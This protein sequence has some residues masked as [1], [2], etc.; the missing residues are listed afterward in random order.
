MLGHVVS[1]GIAIGRVK[2]IE[3]FKPIGIIK[4]DHVDKEISLLESSHVITGDELSDLI[5]KTRK[6]L[7]DKEAQIFEAHKMIL[8]DPTLMPQ[9]VTEITKEELT[10]AS[11]IEKI[12]SQ[13]EVMFATMDS[14]YMKER[15]LDIVDIK[16]RWI[17]NTLSSKVS[18]ESASEPVILFAEELTPSDTLEMDLDLVVGLIMEKGGVASH[19]AILAQSM[20]IPAV[21]GCGP[22]TLVHNELIVLDADTPEIHNDLTDAMIKEFSEKIEEQKALKEALKSYIGLPTTTKDGLNVELA[23][24]IAGPKDI[25]DVNNND[26]EG[27]GLFRTEFVYMNRHSAPDEDEQYKIYEKVVKGLNQ[28]P[29]IFRTMDIGGDKEV[30]YI[31]IPQEYNPFLGYRAIRYCLDHIDFFKTQ[32]RAIYRASEHGNIKIMFPMIGNIREF[33]DAKAIALEARQELISEGLEIKEIALGIMIEIPSAAIQAEQFAK[34]VDF[35]SIG[36][37]DLTQ[38]TLAVDRQNEQINELYDYFDPAVLSLIKHVIEV[39]IKTNTWVGMCGSA[40]GDME[41]IPLLVSWG[42]NELSMPASLVL[43]ARGVIRDLDSTNYSDVF[44]KLVEL[45]DGKSVRRYLENN[46]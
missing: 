7:G 38:Y 39:G 20:G 35:F 33:L 22:I 28:K 1:K 4:S 25:E 6:D 3:P 36:T 44:D 29:I 40:A 16:K 15:A 5:T 24:N 45:N 10:A 11:A 21:V 23:A 43:K 19:T 34:H 2:R 18:K 27:V 31:D 12:L 37:N 9:I 13:M 14:D 26:A 17:T 46:C 42:I 41:M 30:P 8:E 32:L